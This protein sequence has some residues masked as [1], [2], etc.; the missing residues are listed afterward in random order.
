MVTG[1]LDDWSMVGSDRFTQEALVRSPAPGPMRV[2]RGFPG[3]GWGKV[4]VSEERS[5]GPG[6]EVLSRSGG[7]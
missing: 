2:R 3:E 7:G 4:G 1:S 5:W 6:D